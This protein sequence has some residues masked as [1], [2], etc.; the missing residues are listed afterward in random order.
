VTSAALGAIPLAGAFCIGEIGPLEDQVS[1]HGF[2]AT[3]GIL[4]RSE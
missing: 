2:T 3:L 1:L 4:L